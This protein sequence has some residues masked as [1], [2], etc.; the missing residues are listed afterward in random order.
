MRYNLPDKDPRA[1]LYGKG[2]QIDQRTRRSISSYDPAGG[3]TSGPTDDTNIYFRTSG[4]L[5][6]RGRLRM[7]TW[8]I[9]LE[10]TSPSSAPP[11]GS[12]LYCQAVTDATNR[13]YSKDDDGNVHDLTAHS[14]QTF[15]AA[16]YANETTENL[17]W[18]ANK[19]GSG[20]ISSLASTTFDFTNEEGDN[21]RGQWT[22]GASYDG[23]DNHTADFA[24]IV[25]YRKFG[26]S[27]GNCRVL[28]KAL[29]MIQTTH[30]TS[31]D[32]ADIID[33]LYLG[34]NSF[35]TAETKADVLST[36]VA[37]DQW[38]DLTLAT[39]GTDIGAYTMPRAWLYMKAKRHSGEEPVGSY[40]LNV[41]IEH[42]TVEQWA[43]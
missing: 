26:D 22:I 42:I 8:P 23:A 10:E 18:A 38:Y 29:V 14:K 13:T 24:F 37:Y 30:P 16:P 17:L 3:G 28:I 15:P 36:V 43:N 21:A 39:S 25:P 32:P 35:G 1:R 33:N 27:N 11:D 20:T 2:R 34:T 7:D 5:K 12:I 31:T 9:E 19:V 4:E 40:N 6:M 41:Y